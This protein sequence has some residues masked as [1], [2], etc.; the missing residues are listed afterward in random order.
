MHYNEEQIMTSYPIDGTM[1]CAGGERVRKLSMVCL[2]NNGYTIV[3]RGI[4]WAVSQKIL[5][6]RFTLRTS[7]S[8]WKNTTRSFVC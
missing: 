8:S 3:A 1:G 4:L 6:L 2:H 5:R 7:S